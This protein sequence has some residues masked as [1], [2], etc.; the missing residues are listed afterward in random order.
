LRKAIILSLI[1]IFSGCSTGRLS[2]ERKKTDL[3]GIANNI[4]EELGKNNISKRDF[5][6]LKGSVSFKEADKSG[7]YL[8]SLRHKDPNCYLLSLRNSMGIEGARIFMTMDT[9]LINDRINR[10]VLYGRPEILIRLTGIPG[11]FKELLFGDIILNKNQHSGKVEVIDN[12]IYVSQSI[13]GFHIKSQIDINVK[14]IS[15]TRLNKGPGTNEVQFTYQSFYKGPIPF[16]R[17]IL[18]K[19]SNSSIDALIRIDKVDFGLID[20]LKFVPGKNY[21]YE[22]IK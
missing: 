15:N 22:E 12:K 11:V 4:L 6:I 13:D 7:K 5:S 17:K 8:F 2:S 3:T 19:S 14:K 1:V 20:S 21:M 10:R 9:V 18:I 16:P